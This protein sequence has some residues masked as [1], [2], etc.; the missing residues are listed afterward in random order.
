MSKGQILGLI[1]LAIL[2]CYLFPA[3]EERR[4]AELD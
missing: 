3:G 4:D 2:A 1:L